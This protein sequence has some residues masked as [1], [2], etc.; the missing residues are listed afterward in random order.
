[1]NN[2]IILGSLAS[3]LKRVSMSLQRKSFS[4]ADRFTQEALKRKKE[5]NAEEIE[6]Y[7]RKILKHVEISLN[8]ERQERTAEDLLMYSTLIQNYVLYK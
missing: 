7:L 6:P 2:N 5:V 3:D 4:T 1:M 8:S